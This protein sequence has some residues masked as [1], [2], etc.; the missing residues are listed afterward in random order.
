MLRWFRLACCL[1]ACLA[2]QALALAQPLPPEIEAALVQAELPRDAITVLVAPAEGGPAR[3][4]HRIDAPV[5]PASIAKLATTF[6]ALELLGPTYTWT[7]PVYFDGPVREGVLQGNLVIKGQ[8]DP[9]LVMERLWLLLHQVQSLG[10]RSIAGDLV[11][12]RSAFALPPHDPAAFDGLPLRPYNASPDALLVNYKAV[13]LTITPENGVARVRADPPLAGVQWPATVPVAT[14]TECGDW[15]TAL[16]AD[17]RNLA[18][19]RFAG[20]FPGSCGERVWQLAFP[21]PAGYS[22]RA[23]AALWRDMGG[24]VRGV[25]RD[26]TVPAGLKPAFEFASPPLA[27]VVRDINKYSNNVMAQQVFLTLSLQQRGTGTFEG[28]REVLGAWWRERFGGE[29]PVTQNG[30]GLSRTESITARQLGQLLQAAWVSPLMP[31]LT[32]SLPALGLDGTLRR[33]RQNVGLAHLKT[34]S[35]NDV[36]GVAGY[37][38]GAQGRRWILVAIANHPRRAGAIRNVVPALVEWAARLQ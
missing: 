36:S 22:L 24:Q 9:K 5:N 20:R 1:L 31:D 19:V 17:F 12:D 16:G 4:A 30:S 25:V 11:L 13:T 35:L 15:I 27:E 33:Q 32:A 2:A 34:G 8:G 28:S 29:A 37:V 14:G 26:G 38:H 6:A 7:T 3:I 23:V 21:D 10:V 18:Q